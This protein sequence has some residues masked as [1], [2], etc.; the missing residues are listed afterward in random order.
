MSVQGVPE[1]TCPLCVTGAVSG[2]LSPSGPVVLGRPVQVPTT[3]ICI[4]VSEGFSVIR[5]GGAGQQCLG[6]DTPGELG[7]GPSILQTLS[8]LLACD[9]NLS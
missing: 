1:D 5:E 8:V 7:R 6:T 4:C 9:W 3:R 2:R